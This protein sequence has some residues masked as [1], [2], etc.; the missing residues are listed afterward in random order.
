MTVSVKSQCPHCD[1][2]RP[3]SFSPRRGMMLHSVY[4]TDADGREWAMK[5]EFTRC[6]NYDVECRHLAEPFGFYTFAWLPRRC[7]NGRKRW[8]CWVERH[9]DGTYTYGNR[10]H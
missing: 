1:K 5:G 10:A 2:G 7:R 4:G 6:R 9:P 3:V 8:L